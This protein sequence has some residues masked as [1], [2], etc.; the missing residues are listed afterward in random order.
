MFNLI[1]SSLDLLYKY[2]LRRRQ[3]ALFRKAKGSNNRRKAFEIVVRV[4][5]K[6]SNTRL[7]FL[8][9]LSRQLVD[10]NQVIIAENLCV[11]GLAR[12]KLAFL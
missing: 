2:P 8:H 9:Q 5:E 11:K 4:H 3:K 10:E 12:T 6:I 1:S 7:D